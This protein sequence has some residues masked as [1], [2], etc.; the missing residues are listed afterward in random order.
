MR[1]ERKMTA[2]GDAMALTR[3]RLFITGTLMAALWL[4]PV[5][6]AAQSGTAAKGPDNKAM[7]HALEDAFASVADRVMPSV[8][9]V[10]VKPKKAPPGEGGQPPEGEQRFRDFFG[11]EFYDRFFRRRAPREEAR[12]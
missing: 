5:A 3:D 4:L 9:N 1:R 2:P 10:S 12:S 11:P 7:L 6:A 8:V